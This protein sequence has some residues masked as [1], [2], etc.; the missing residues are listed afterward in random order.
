MTTVRPG[1]AHPGYLPAARKGAAAAMTNLASDYWHIEPYDPDALKWRYE[2]EGGY[3]HRD[4][5]ISLLSV[6]EFNRLPDGTRLV[7]IF[8]EEFIKGRDT[9]DDDTRGGR[10]AFG[11]LPEDL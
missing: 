4:K 9:I 1:A 5:D 2:P 8:G 10:L 3:P 6:E 7:S 11:L